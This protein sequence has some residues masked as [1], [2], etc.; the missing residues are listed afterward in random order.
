MATDADI[1]RNGLLKYRILFM[2]TGPNDFNI[3]GGTG[4]IT[5]RLKLDRESVSYYKLWCEVTDDGV[6]SLTGMMVSPFI[7]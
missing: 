2:L 5:S 4:V 6:P 1:G 3:D 7:N